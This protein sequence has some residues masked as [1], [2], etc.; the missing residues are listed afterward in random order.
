MVQ[1]AF[2]QKY[3]CFIKFL[4]ICAAIGLIILG[5][6][7]FLDFNLT[8]P[9]EYIMSIYYIVF[10]VVLIGLVLD[11]DIIKKYFGVFSSNVGKG[12]LCIFIGTLCI[13]T[14]GS[15]AFCIIMAICLG[16]L[17]GIYL[18]AACMRQ[19]KAPATATTVAATPEQV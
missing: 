10:G 16:V 2:L 6:V 12:C 11:M 7:S 13:R 3:N 15:D 18:S 19:E 5:I 4:T 14:D 17:G 8:D 9:S 1:R